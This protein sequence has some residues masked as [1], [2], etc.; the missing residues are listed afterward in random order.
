M[1][2]NPRMTLTTGNLTPKA[3]VFLVANVLKFGG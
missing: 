3:A 2:E 1:I